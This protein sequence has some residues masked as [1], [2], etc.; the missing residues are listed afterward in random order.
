M[1]KIL[2]GFAASWMGLAAFAAQAQEKLG[3]AKPW[4]LGFQLP[5][6]P[7]MEKLET[8]HDLILLPIITVITIFVLILMVYIC[9]RFRR[10]ANPVPS[11]TTHNTLLE[12]VWTVI[13]IIILVIIAIPSLRVHYFMHNTADAEMTLK[14]TGRQWYWS[15]EYPDQGGISF[16]SYMKKDEELKEGEP[17]L[18]TVDN[19]LVLPVNTNIRLQMTGADVIHAWAMP[20]MGI[21]RDAMPG[22]LNEAWFKAEKEGIYYGQCSELCGTGHGF[23]PIEMHIVSKE[24][25]N[26][27]VTSKKPV[28]DATP[29][30]PAAAR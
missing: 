12:V 15:Y 28:A 16:D 18:L 10:K 4:Q 11:R 21:K 29:A 2:I 30:K 8:L 9:V 1:K 27:W 22:R 23:M 14:I 20:T 7:V 13:P 19:P 17:R 5:Y 26:A 6:S 25:F 24:A 3:Y